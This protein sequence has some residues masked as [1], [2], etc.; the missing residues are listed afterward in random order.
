MKNLLKYN[1]VEYF[2]PFLFG[3][4]IFIPILHKLLE[5]E[6]NPVKFVY[7]SP[8]CEWGVG[9][10]F[11]IFKL[12]NL[13]F[14][15]GYFKRLITKYKVTPTLTFTNLNVQDRLN[16]EYCNNLLD[17][18][19]S[20]DCRIL[21]SKDELYNHIKT[22][23]PE[24]KIHSSVIIPSIK[25]VEDKTFDE[26]R[27]YNEMLDKCEVVV[28]RP[29][30]TLNN[31]DKLD[32]LLYDLSRIEVL[33]NQYC[34]FDCP[35]HRAHYRF[36]E[37]LNKGIASKNVKYY[38]LDN[39][40]KFSLCP[41]F[42]DNHRSVYFTKEQVEKV[43]EIGVRKIKLQ[44]RAS[45]FY[46][47]YDE[48]YKNIFNNEYSKEEIRNKMDKICAEMLQENMLMALFMTAQSGF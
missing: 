7:G 35:H 44:G 31:I 5:N 4:D 17:I 39:E 24:A 30:Y 6:V 21:V 37:E 46:W 45:Q 32:K 15:E 40:E 12:D 48:L 11:T 27:F 47:L 3:N 28:I 36:T 20:L 34:Q 38:T 43:L 10:R 41:K 1:D 33:T 8:L 2:M 18:A 42:S 16:D 29:E 22:R 19:C 23:Y 13:N 25:V 26:T 14:V 9:A